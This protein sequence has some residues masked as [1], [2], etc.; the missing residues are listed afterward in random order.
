MRSGQFEMRGG[1]ASISLISLN[2]PTLLIVFAEI[3]P[4]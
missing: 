3:Q 1:R 2:A 4:Q